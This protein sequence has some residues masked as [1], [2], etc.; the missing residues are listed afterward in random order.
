MYIKNSEVKICIYVT[1]V[2]NSFFL[3]NSEIRFTLKSSKIYFSKE[4]QLRR[5]PIR[6]RYI[7][8]QK[9]GQKIDITRNFEINM[10]YVMQEKGK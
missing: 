10:V 3:I 5:N 9:E 8:Y 2:I 1:Q 7:Y 4:F 6:N